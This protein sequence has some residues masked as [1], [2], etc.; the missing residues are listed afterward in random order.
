MAAKIFV[1]GS[2]N[3]KF[4]SA[5][6]KLAT[7]HQKQN[8]AFAI[9]TGDLF[10]FDQDEDS[11]S[12]LLNGEIQIPIS[13]YFTIGTIPLPDRVVE[14]VEKGEDVCENLHFLG[15]R[16]ITKTS[17][18]VRIVVLGGALDKSIV[19]G[20]SNE[21]HLPLHTADDAKILRGANTADILLTTC[22]PSGIWSNS[23]KPPALEQQ[24]AIAS[25]D[26]IAELCAA[27]KPRYH[28]AAAYGN[29]FYEREPF[30]HP[31]SGPESDQ[32]PVTRFISL[33][34]YGNEAKA[35]AMYAFNLV[36]GEA[37]SSTVPPG[38]TASPFL[39]KT[40]PRKR[41]APGGDNAGHFNDH[42][43]R[44][45]GRRVRRRK[46]RSPPPG[47]D[48][49][50]FCLSNTQVDTHMICC[51]GDDSYV[52]TAKGP[53]PSSDTFA[54]SGLSFPGHQLIIPLP[55]EPTVRAMGEDAD[56]TYKEMTRFKESM[57]AMIATESKFKLG[58]VTWEISRQHGIH[59]HW[60]FI[61][62][63]S[64]L[65]RKG[66]VEAGFKVEAENRQFPPFEEVALESGIDE[67]SDYFR[68]WI[69]ADDSDTGIQSKELVMR[70]DSKTRF[71]LQFGRRV[72]A[73]LLGLESRITWKDVVQPIA[74]ETEDVQKFKEAFKPWDF[75]A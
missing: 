34:P 13:T 65:I 14:R 64:D 21:Q 49:C 59:V 48:Q 45:G 47:P 53:L 31:P 17:D 70:L 7:L 5:F 69:W 9:I 6:Q 15:K 24:T 36:P 26:E 1:L 51:I 11:L 72:I 61:P 39:P 27:L 30:F 42:D 66:L 37:P 74:E 71:D 56:K 2:V 22:W 62:V 18:G 16:S 41:P 29:F 73:K 52:T 50:F 4:E 68:V 8:F 10:T 57:Q 40:N 23:S 43:H 33:A 20:Q 35:K 63:P 25:S 58:A 12:R 32:L 67:T 19:G 38:S 54:S 60:Q 55:H 75:T 44:G 46:D 28:F 3:G